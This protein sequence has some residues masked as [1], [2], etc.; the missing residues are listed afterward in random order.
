[1]TRRTVNIETLLAAG[2]HV[3][4]DWKWH[5]INGIFA[6]LAGVEG[7]ILA[8]L[9]PRNCPI[10]LRTFG[11]HIREEIALRQ[12]L[13]LRLVMHVLA[14]AKRNHCKGCYE[15]EFSEVCHALAGHLRNRM[16]LQRLEEAPRLGAAVFRVRREN[17]QEKAI[18]G[19]ERESRHVKDRVIWH[20]QPIQ[21]QHAEHGRETGEQDRHLKRDHNKCRP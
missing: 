4:S 19:G 1:M 7:N 6:N 12:R 15:S 8:Q 14:A 5:V 18:L 20:W 11:P 21:R 10:D 17:D 9:A 3:C 2:E 16:W 13:V